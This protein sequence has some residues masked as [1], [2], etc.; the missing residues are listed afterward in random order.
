M[1]RRAGFTLLE[2]LL[3]ISLTSAVAIAAVSLTLFQA[4]I[5]AASR[6]QAETL[7]LVT[8]T[9]R[10]LND[11]LLLAVRQPG[12]GRAQF[13]EGGTL[14]LVTSR[15]LPGEEP[16]LREVVW[17]WDA[18]SGSVL[19]TALAPGRPPSTRRVGG[20]WTAFAIESAQDRL[21]LRGSVGDGPDWRLP[22]W[23]ET[24]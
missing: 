7:A 21:W 1:S 2:L 16:G 23:T 22:L 5:A 13:G 6:T 14:R 12:Q 8:E 9:I 4:R 24:P 20:G 15:R 19:R 10:V 11:D 3:A 18:D 17:G